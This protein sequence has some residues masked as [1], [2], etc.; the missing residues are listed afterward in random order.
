[1]S[2]AARCELALRGIA[3]PTAEQTAGATLGALQ[4]EDLRR[5]CEAYVKDG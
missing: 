4:A 5:L 2:T 1:M 3:H